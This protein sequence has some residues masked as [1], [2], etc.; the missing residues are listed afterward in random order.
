MVTAM[1]PGNCGYKS[2]TGGILQNLRESTSNQ[3]V[4][5]RGGKASYNNISSVQDFA[6]S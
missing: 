4:N 6:Q 5:E 3:K 2:E 1:Y